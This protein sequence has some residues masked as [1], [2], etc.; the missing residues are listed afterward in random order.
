MMM[1]VLTK[2][3]HYTETA[4]I[5]LFS[6]VIHYKQSHHSVAVSCFCNLKHLNPVLNIILLIY[7]YHTLKIV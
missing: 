6:R 5:G 2:I 1:V 4:L 7:T 3:G